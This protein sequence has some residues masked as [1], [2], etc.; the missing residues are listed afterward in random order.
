MPDK[1]EQN[2]LDWFTSVEEMRKT[3][4]N[5]NYCMGCYAP[6]D[7][8]QTGKHLLLCFERDRII[9]DKDDRFPRVQCLYCDTYRTLRMSSVSRKWL[10]ADLDNNDYFILMKDHKKFCSAEPTKACGCYNVMQGVN[11]WNPK[12]T[13]EN[14]KQMLEYREK[15]I[16][17][18]RAYINE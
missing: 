2:G 8:L 3:A 7:T 1:K 13:K 17:E 18:R 15:E 6:E 11:T 4:V 5:S 10:L 12:H 16:E 14:I 9:F